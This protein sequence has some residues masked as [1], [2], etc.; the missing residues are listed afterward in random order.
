ML[1]YACIA[2]KVAEEASGLPTLR[3]G[4]Q[5]YFMLHGTLFIVMH[6]VTAAGLV[7]VRGQ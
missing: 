4:C 7:S 1:A 5:Q 2:G 3:G 6:Q